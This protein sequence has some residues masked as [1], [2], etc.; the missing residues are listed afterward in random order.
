MKV[1]EITLEEFSKEEAKGGRG[2]RGGVNKE[3]M[4]RAKT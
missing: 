2:R 1:E 3:L 4:E